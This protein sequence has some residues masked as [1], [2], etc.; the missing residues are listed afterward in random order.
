MCWILSVHNFISIKMYTANIYSQTAVEVHSKTCLLSKSTDLWLQ[1]FYKY[2]IVLVANNNCYYY[3][4]FNAFVNA[5]K[6]KC[7]VQL[8]TAPWNTEK[9]MKLWKGKAV[10]STLKHTLSL[11]KRETI[12]LATIIGRIDNFMI[13]IFWQGDKL[14]GW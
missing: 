3:R 8:I 9:L 10:E 1:F 4:Y 7:K 5:G 11:L 12:L 2:F 6:L 13:V 14:A